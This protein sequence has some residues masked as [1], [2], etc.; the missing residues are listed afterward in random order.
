MITQDDV[1]QAVN[2]CLQK[3]PPIGGYKLCQD[4][5]VLAEVLGGMFARNLKAIEP[6]VLQGE[7]LEAFNRWRAQA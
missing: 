4:A 3:N 1:L 6:A 5:N 7:H 2:R